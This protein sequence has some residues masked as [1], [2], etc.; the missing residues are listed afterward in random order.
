MNA[1]R[2]QQ[3]DKGLSGLVAQWFSSRGADSAV[4]DAM[5]QHRVRDVHQLKEMA[6]RGA[7]WQAISEA[8]AKSPELLGQAPAC[9]GLHL[10]STLR[11][12]QV[13]DPQTGIIAV[14]LSAVAGNDF[15]Y[16]I[17]QIPSLVLAVSGVKLAR[18]DEA[19]TATLRASDSELQ[20]SW[21]P[22]QIRVIPPTRPGLI[23]TV[24]S[25][26]GVAVETAPVPLGVRIEQSVPYLSSV[27][28]SVPGSET[29]VLD[30]P[31]SEED[32]LSVRRG[33]GITKLCDPEL[34]DEMLLMPVRLVPLAKRAPGVFES[35]TAEQAPGVAFATIN[36]PIEFAHILC[37]EYHHLRLFLLEELH[38]L[39]IDPTFPVRAPWRTDVR[40]LKSLLH[41]LYVFDRVAA[42]FDR[43][44]DRWKPSERGVRRMA[45]W[46]SCIDAAL[47]EL[48]ASDAQLTEA[49]ILLT[50]Q[51]QARNQEEL[52]RLTRE[53]PEPAAWAAK[54]VA[55]HMAQAGS[56][57]PGEAWF[58]AV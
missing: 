20:I 25:S 22:D 24:I 10:R 27:P 58:L 45:V 48:A 54:V 50:E 6:S 49:G 41:G 33:L 44:F 2:Q 5:S 53:H 3:E 46:R 21:G 55:E 29:R 35:L 7:D 26:N 51:I 52:P 36:D 34:F 42:L 19:H 23:A 13:E 30:S 14:E 37:H 9:A 8:A 39:S 47:R 56:K 31:L 12:W 57:E 15:E 18:A 4:L 11:D 32:L 43:V 38:P 1:P 28:T 17:S 16:T 40:K